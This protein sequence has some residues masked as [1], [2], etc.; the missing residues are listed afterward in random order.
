MVRV[1]SA[2]GSL[3]C[4]ADDLGEGVETA[5]DVGERDGGGFVR[6]HSGSLPSWGRVADDHDAVAAIA[7]ALV[8]MTRTAAATGSVLSSLRGDGC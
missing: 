2:K 3:G 1:G 5:V 4:G 6:W 8:C 7:A